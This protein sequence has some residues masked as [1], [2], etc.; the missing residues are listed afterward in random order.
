MVQVL[1][2]WLRSRKM[3]ENVLWLSFTN[4][5][6]VQVSRLSFKCKA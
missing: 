4:S 2:I 1:G 6:K 3:F 5:V